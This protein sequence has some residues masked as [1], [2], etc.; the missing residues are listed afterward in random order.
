MDDVKILILILLVLYIAYIIY[1]YLLRPWI[2][3]KTTKDIEVN[4]KWMTPK[5]REKYYG[6]SDIDIIL[7]ETTFGG[8]PRIRLSKDN[9]IQLLLPEDVSPRDIDEIAQIVLAA[10]VRIKYGLWFPDKPAFWL[11]ILCYMLDGGDIKQEAT[12]WEKIDKRQE[13]S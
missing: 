3:E 9:R 6:F 13:T 8:L 7:A 4:P 10:K 11:S 1:K 5:L 2:L 12:S